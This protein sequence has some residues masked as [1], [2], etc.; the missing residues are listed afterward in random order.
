MSSKLNL[1]MPSIAIQ[2]IIR[3]CTDYKDDQ[4]MHQV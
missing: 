1:L 2:I 4:Q 3:Q